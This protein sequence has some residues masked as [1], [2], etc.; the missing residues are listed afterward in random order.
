M[1]VAFAMLALLVACLHADDYI[2]AK[3][4]VV[5]HANDAYEKL[6][7]QLGR[8]SFIIEYS[9]SSTCPLHN[10]QVRQWVE[11]QQMANALIFMYDSDQSDR[12]A[13]AHLAPMRSKAGKFIPRLY[14]M[15]AEMIAVDVIPYDTD[16]KIVDDTLGKLFAK[17]RLYLTQEQYGEI[18]GMVGRIRKSI[19]AG[20][21][22]SVRVDVRKMLGLR[23]KLSGSDLVA[24]IDALVV[25]LTT[26]LKTEVDQ[27]DEAKRKPRIASI[28]TLYKGII[29]EDGIAEIV[30]R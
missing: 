24:K 7:A 16:A 28:E 17:G 23:S 29:P 27:M 11:R 10:S 3:G 25:D 18:D 13:A 1:P 21:P 4:C 6:S 2:P 20:K 30:G 15:N 22:D 9:K 19:Q 14:V 5:A 12:K 8:P 26:Q